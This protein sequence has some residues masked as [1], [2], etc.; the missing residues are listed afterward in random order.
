MRA[1]PPIVDQHEQ[2]N[3]QGFEIHVAPPFD[4]YALEVKVV[5]E[6]RTVR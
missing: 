3:E 5:I 2:R 6:R 4:W 1:L